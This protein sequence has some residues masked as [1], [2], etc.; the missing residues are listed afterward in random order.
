M[1]IHL[2]V[3]ASGE[4]KILIFAVNPK[5]GELTSQGEM[6]VSGSPANMAID[7]GGQF[8]YIVR[9]SNHEISTCR[10]N[11]ETGGLS[12]IGCLLQNEIGRSC[13]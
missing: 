2:Y 6:V 13:K 8:V 10:R 12:L 9:K 5:T 7:P 4:D 1:P 3:S 11:L